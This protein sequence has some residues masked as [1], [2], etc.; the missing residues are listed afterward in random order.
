M[1]NH[2]TESRKRPLSE[3]REHGLL[4]LV[5][6]TVFHPR[7]FAL[8]LD[9]EDDG[10]VTGWGMFGDGTE[11]WSF[12]DPEAE[13]ADFVKV[14]AFLNSL[15]PQQHADCTQL[16]VFEHTVAGVVVRCLLC[17]AEADPVVNPPWHGQHIRTEHP[18]YVTWEPVVIPEFDQ[19]TEDPK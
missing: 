5:N 17:G 6:K 9:V 19:R 12:G 14:E 8:Y 1:P 4:W 13:D 2:P 10:S 15:R 11:S 7:G 16:V 3:F 18:Q